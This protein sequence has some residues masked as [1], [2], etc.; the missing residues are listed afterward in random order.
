MK[1][2]ER[3]SFYTHLSGVIF[4]IIGFVFLIKLTLGNSSLMLLSAVYS[5]SL[6][7]LFSASSLYHF[8]KKEENEISFWRK[9]DHVAIFFMIAGSY[10]P[11]CYLFLDGYWK[12]GTIIFQ[13]VLVF[14]GLLFKLFFLNA[15]RFLNTTIYL[16][17]G[18]M[19]IVLM[20]TLY[21]GMPINIFYL[22]MMGAAAYTVGAIIYGFKK[23]ILFSGK[24]G[25]HE[26]FHVFI[27]IG[28]TL[29]FIMIYLGMAN[30]VNVN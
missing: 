27:L 13:W 20:P 6:I 7:F 25:F 26:I 18:W 9:L 28:A 17:M 23:P 1:K 14:L 19:A 8:F 24:F 2:I 15:P 3:I 22:L 30:L 21:F 4:A 10:T 29:H 12:I 11:I 5:F 16:L